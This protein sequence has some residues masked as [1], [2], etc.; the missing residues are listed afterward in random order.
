[1]KKSKRY[2]SRP[3]RV[4]LVVSLQDRRGCGGERNTTTNELVKEKAQA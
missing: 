3:G 1:M 2:N 4:L